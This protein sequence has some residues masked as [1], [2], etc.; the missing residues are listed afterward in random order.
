MGASNPGLG[1]VDGGS[2]VVLPP[3]TT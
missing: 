1:T 2:A 3:R